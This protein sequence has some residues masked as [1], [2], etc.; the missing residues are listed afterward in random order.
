MEQANGVT[1]GSFHIGETPVGSGHPVYVIAE[2]AQAHDGSLGTAHAY[3]DLASTL[4][5][6]AVKFQ[7]HIA[8]AESTPA[9]PWRVKFSPQDDTRFEYWERMEFTESQWKGLAD[10]CAETGIE[11]LSSAFS[12]EA[13]ELL[14][15]LDMAAWKLASGELT[16]TEMVDLML[17]TGRPLLTSSGMSPVAEIDELVNRAS[18]RG[19]PIAVFQC[20]SSYPCPP[21][22][23]GLNV[24]SEFRDRWAVPV[25]LSDHSGTIYPGLAATVLGASL[26]EVHLTFSHDVFGPDVASS[27]APQQLSDLIA[28][29]RFLEVAMANPVDKNLAAQELAPMRALFTKS[30]VAAHDLLEG[31]ILREADLLSRKPGSGI[32]AS[33]LSDIVGR[34]LSRPVAAYDLLSDADLA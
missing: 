11:F 8:A 34:T 27:L 10:H 31:T 26:L 24:I 29:I 32:P 30:L 18:D 5:A 28:G 23:L 6:N 19:T 12:K 33:S 7:T 14:D 2:I 17:D 20:T 25:G 22:T 13:V 3:I 9:E 4:G 16:N 21:E 15:S 1:G